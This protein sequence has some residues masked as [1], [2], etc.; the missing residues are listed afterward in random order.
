MRART[1]ERDVAEVVVI[2]PE[3]SRLGGCRL[4]LGVEGRR[5][6]GDLV[7]PAYQNV[8]IVTLRHMMLLVGSRGG[9]LEVE[10]RR[11]ARVLR[12]GP[13]RGKQRER[14]DGCGNGGGC[15]NALCQVAARQPLCNDVPHGEIRRGVGALVLALL[16]LPRYWQAR[17]IVVAHGSLLRPPARVASQASQMRIRRARQL[18][19]SGALPQ[20]QPSTRACD[21][22][23]A[24]RGY[25][26][27][28]RTSSGG[29]SASVRISRSGA[30]GSRSRRWP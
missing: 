18:C 30:P 1:G 23:C 3:L 19:D 6:L 14:G 17:K 24:R 2:V 13:L 20:R 5:I 7:A 22:R 10:R 9:F 27:R 16:V 15:K 26:E 4:L 11:R 8:G 25:P 29:S 12:V 21:C 28:P